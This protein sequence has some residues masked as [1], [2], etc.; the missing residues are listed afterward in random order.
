[1]QGFV[2]RLSET[3]LSVRHPVP[4]AGQHTEEVLSEWIGYDR[5][6]VAH[7]KSNNLV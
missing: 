3:D 4:M 6:D 2:T 7:L 1:M 5:D